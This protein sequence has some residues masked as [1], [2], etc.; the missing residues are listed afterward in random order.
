MN[1][2]SFPVQNKTTAWPQDP[3]IKTG[4]LSL[5]CNPLAPVASAL[6]GCLR[7]KCLLLPRLGGGGQLDFRWPHGRNTS[8]FPIN[9]V[10]LEKTA[11]HN[12]YNTHVKKRF[13]N[14][15]E[16]HDRGFVEPDHPEKVY[17]AKEK[18]S[19]D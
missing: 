18:A 11:F 5:R 2:E 17:L 13:K 15:A 10:G 12:G 16:S 19:K 8:P 3:E 6:L 7:V 4:E 1:H 14:V 9:R